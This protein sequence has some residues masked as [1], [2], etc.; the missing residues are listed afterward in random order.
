MQTEA[1]I[2]AG[3]R[4]APVEREPGLLEVA[5]GSRGCLAGGSSIALRNAALCLDCERVF[6]GDQARATCPKCASEAL[7]W[8]QPVLNRPGV[9]P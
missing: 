5:S 1:E 6:D 7:L 3:V 9:R 2:G 8:L 4:P